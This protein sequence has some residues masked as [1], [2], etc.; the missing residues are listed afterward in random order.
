MGTA[1][2]KAAE[3]IWGYN[4]YLS[5]FHSDFSKT[6]SMSFTLGNEIDFKMSRPTLGWTMAAPPFI[7]FTQLHEKLLRT[8]VEVG[9][10]VQYGYSSIEL[11]VIGRGR[12]ADIIAKL[13][14]DKAAPVG[15]FRSE[16][17]KSCLPLGVV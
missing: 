17:L 15:A 14:L 13:G 3:E 10:K 6:E 2:A 9:H 5:K 11:N 12:T 4:K 16:T 1:K 7:T 8:V